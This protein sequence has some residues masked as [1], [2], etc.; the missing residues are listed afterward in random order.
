[1]HEFERQHYQTL[2]QKIG[3][4]TSFQFGKLC[5]DILMCKPW[6]FEVNCIKQSI[7]LLKTDKTCILQVLLGKSNVDLDAIQNVYASTFDKN[8]IAHLKKHLKP[9]IE[10]FFVLLLQVALL[11]L[12]SLI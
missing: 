4:E 2:R 11:L 8:L 9:P 3:R 6:E 5:D 10:T 7:T 12:F 1:M